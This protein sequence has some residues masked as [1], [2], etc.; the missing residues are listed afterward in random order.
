MKKRDNM[1]S[2]LEDDE[3]KGGDACFAAPFTSKHSNSIKCVLIIMRQSIA[4]LVTTIQ[5]YKILAISS[6]IQAYSLAEMNLTNLKYSQSQTT[7]I[8]ILAS[9]NLYYFSNAEPLKKISHVRAPHTIFNIW[10]AIS[11]F[12]QMAIFVFCN[13]YALN[14]IGLRYLPEEDKNISADV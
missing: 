4:V 3:S 8:G 9:I 6:M 13:Y 14:H 12:G 10:F 7:V 5:T 1:F 2:F 11:F